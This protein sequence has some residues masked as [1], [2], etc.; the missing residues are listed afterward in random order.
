MPFSNKPSKMALSELKLISYKEFNAFIKGRDC[1][2]RNDYALKDLKAKFDFKPLVKRIPLVV[3]LEDMESTQFASMSEAVK[4]ISMGEKAIRYMRNN[5][6]DVV[7]K[8]EGGNINFLA[9]KMP[10]STFKARPHPLNLG[11][12]KCLCGQTFDYK[13]DRDLGDEVPNAS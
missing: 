2:G 1:K 6:R 3:S 13:S 5:G 8:S 12:A 9:H 4:T 10:C 11:V 7:R